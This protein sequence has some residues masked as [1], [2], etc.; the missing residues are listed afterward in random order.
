MGKLRDQMVS[1]LV[2]RNYSPKTVEAY[3]WAMFHFVKHFRR[4]PDLMGES[5]I[6]E[7]LLYLVEERKASPSL[8]KMFVAG[9]K[10]F[11]RV[12]LNRPE[13][14]ERIPYPKIPK[15]LPDVLTQEEVAAIINAVGSVKYRAIIAT[16]YAAGLRI[17]EA[18]RLYARG[19]ID[20]NRMLIHIRAGKGGKDRYVMFGERLLM[21]LREYWTQTRPKGLYLFPG[22]D[23]DQPIS[24][25][26]VYK[27][28]KKALEK[29][30]ITKHVTLHTLRHSCATHLTEAHTD[31]RLIQVLLGHGSI[32]TT[33]RYTHVSA[34][35]IGRIKSPFESLSLEK[36]SPIT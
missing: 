23:P 2:L 19:D 7:F 25:D 16:T 32:R 10:F 21:L 26:S 14:V 27:V 13:A 4:S 11:Y 15:T 9:I 6:R 17:S 3:T 31:I 35:L 5:E 30:G 8:R 36:T 34:E 22:Q 12:T 24:P 20:S 18:C 33:S 1:D 28:F 29:T